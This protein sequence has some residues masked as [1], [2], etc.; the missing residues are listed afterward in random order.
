[1]FKLVIEDDEGT[2]T[3]VPL[4]RDQYVVGRKEGSTIRLTERNISREHVKIARENGGRTRYLLE[5]LTSYNGVYVNGLR[6]ATTQELVHGDLIQLGD[7][8]ILFQDETMKSDVPPA[9]LDENQDLKKTV[10]RAFRGST[11]TERP[12]RLVMLVGPTP[13][14][15]YTLDKDRMSIGRAEEAGI[16]VNHNSVSRIHCEV[17]ALGEGRFEIVDQGSSNGVIVNGSE[18]RRSIIE[19][20]DTIELGDVRFRFVAAG[21]VFVPTTEGIQLTAI[22]DRDTSEAVKGRSTGILLPAI[23]GI[24][25]G[26]A[27]LGAVALLYLRRTPS[28]PSGVPSGDTQNAD[29]ERE[30]KLLAEAAA[31]CTKENLCEE[32]H[33][34]VTS[35]IREGSRLR[36]SLDFKIIESTWAE[37]ML[38]RAADATDLSVRKELYKRVADA[39]TVE[40][41][42]RK[43]ADQ[44]LAALNGEAAIPTGPTPS[45]TA[46]IPT[47][48]VPS[49]SASANGTHKPHVPGVPTGSTAASTPGIATRIPVIVPPPTATVSPTANPSSTA[50]AVTSGLAAQQKAVLLPKARAGTISKDDAR[51]LQAACKELHDVECKNLAGKFL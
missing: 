7:Y 30:E 48:T 20:G 40:L 16:S 14:A 33:R 21:Q 3:M 24:V 42:Q 15:E 44:N 8:R 46:P 18:L 43:T 6:V 17:H 27:A 9:E 4:T 1:M 41:S 49:S 28:G 11:L 26:V 47:D 50:P 34:R 51:A 25:L 2:R 5:D 36:E 37:S 22:G 10:P 45:I 31:G 39:T 35:E 12:D 23:L 32:S 29:Y 19:A 38:A 13:G